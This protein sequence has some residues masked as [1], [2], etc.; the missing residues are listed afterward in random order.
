MKD[1]IAI[2]DLLLAIAGV[3]M[4]VWG[5]TGKGNVYR[6]DAIKDKYIELYKKTVK[7]FCL[8]GGAFAIAAGVLEYFQFNQLSAIFFYILCAIVLI[9]FVVTG[10]WTDRNKGKNHQLR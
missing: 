2:F 5:I 3:Y 1:Y 7:L 9:D 8:F 6:T 10:I 4:I